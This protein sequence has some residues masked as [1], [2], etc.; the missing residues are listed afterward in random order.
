MWCFIFKNLHACGGYQVSCSISWNWMLSVFVY[1][2]FQK[3][4]RY[5]KHSSF[6]RNTNIKNYLVYWLNCNPNPYVIIA[7]FNQ[8]FIYYENSC[9]L[10]RF[11]NIFFGLYFWIQFQ[12]D[13]WFRFIIRDKCCD[14]LRRE[15]PDEYNFKA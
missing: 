15:R 2:P 8:C 14:V 11:W 7:D 1:Q 10:L 12:T 5:Y 3:L 4:F 6:K 9:I 13:T